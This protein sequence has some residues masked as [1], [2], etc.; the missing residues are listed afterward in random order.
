MP[1]M[2][3]IALLHWNAANFTWCL[4]MLGLFGWSAAAI[5][6]QS[7]VS[8][9]KQSLIAAAALLFS[10]T[11]VGIYDGNPGVL[12]I[13]LI[14]LAV[15]RSRLGDSIASGLGLGIACCFKPQ[16]AICGLGVLFLWKRW[17]ALSVATSILAVST[18][19][20]VFVVSSGFTEWQW[21]ETEKHNL[22]ASFAPNG[23]SDPTPPSAVA[24]QML[25][26]Q[27]LFSYIS[28]DPTI[29]NRL[30]WLGVGLL[31]AYFLF[32]RM[33]KGSLDYWHDTAF[34]AALTLVVTYH[35]YYDGQ[36]LLL[37]IP[38]LVLLWRKKLWALAASIS[39]C[40]ALLAFPI[41]SWFA[42]RLGPAAT[43]PSFQQLVL[44]RHQPLA[45]LLLCVMLALGKQEETSDMGQLFRKSN[46]AEFMQ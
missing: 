8:K 27:T 45:T 42:N 31:T 1:W 7:G 41:Q 29:Y 26:A 32:Q 22:A 43:S 13:A 44:L 16:L 12:A 33:R 30:N 23:Q 17:R 21:F 2:G 18:L 35:R 3:G 37:T 9:E 15:C 14:A 39:F 34:A 24:W 4:I 40:L 6:R 25:N 36:L 46:E 5:V 28:S 10:P 11:Y 20:G 38:F 19:V